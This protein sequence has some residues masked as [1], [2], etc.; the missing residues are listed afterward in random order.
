MKMSFDRKDEKKQQQ[1]PQEEKKMKK[2][3]KLRG[4]EIVDDE[5][6]MGRFKAGDIVG[7]CLAL[8]FV[9]FVWD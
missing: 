2:F 6:F 9:H 3:I 8:V 7:M 4:G 5:M 1:Q